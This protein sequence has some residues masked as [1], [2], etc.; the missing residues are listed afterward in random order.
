[1]WSHPQKGSLVTVIQPDGEVREMRLHKKDTNPSECG[2]GC[3]PIAMAQTLHTIALTLLTVK[4]HFPE[5]E[6]FPEGYSLAV[7]QD[8][9]QVLER[10]TFAQDLPNS[11][12][13]AKFRQQLLAA[14][15]T[16]EG[17]RFTWRSL[18]GR[19]FFLFLAVG[20]FVTGLTVQG[21][22]EG[23]EMARQG[24][25]LTGLVTKRDGTGGYDP[26]K[27]IRVRFTPQAGQARGKQQ[28]ANIADYL[29][30]ENWEAA[31]T[32]TNVALLYLP[33]KNLTYV[34]ADILRW[35]QDKKWFTLF[36]LGL[37]ILGM[38]CLVLLPR[39]RIGVHSDGQEYIVEK[40]YVLSDDKDMPVSRL[41]L[42][43]SRVLWRLL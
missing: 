9:N 4:S 40:D 42:N 6:A 37:L 35:Q 24:E 38:G 18:G 7:K 43:I 31:K 25:H 16:A 10:W 5:G 39:Y 15:K 21:W 23:D 19:M 26:G 11:P 41:S 3:I 34:E 8:E 30:A 32:G 2:V 22:R 12:E 29:S 14:R 28:E 20:L 1:M 33:S 36:P 17:G 13:I 27:F